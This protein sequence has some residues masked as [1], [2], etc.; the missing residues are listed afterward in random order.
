MDELAD[1]LSAVYSFFAPDRPRRSL[2]T[3][4]ILWLI[5][6]ARRR[7]LPY[8]YLGYWIADC[9]KMSYKTRFRPAE[10]YDGDGW[11]PLSNDGRGLRPARVALATGRRSVL[12]QQLGQEGGDLREQPEQPQPHDLD[13]PRRARRR[14]RCVRW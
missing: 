5:E 4:M 12:R 9:A 10:V 3:H 1:G 11:A 13:P 14:G 2:G 8:A 6:E 7:A